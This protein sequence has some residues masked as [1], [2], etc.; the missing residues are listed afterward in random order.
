M[1]SKERLTKELR[2][3]TMDEFAPVNSPLLG[4]ELKR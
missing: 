1:R 4:F 2:R 3:G